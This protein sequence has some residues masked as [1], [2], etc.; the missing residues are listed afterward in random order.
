MGKRRKK[1]ASNKERV[2][3]FGAEYD[4]SPPRMTKEER[5]KMM[6]EFLSKGGQIQRIGKFGENV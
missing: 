1:Q 4:I 2:S 6:Q 3:S 5:E